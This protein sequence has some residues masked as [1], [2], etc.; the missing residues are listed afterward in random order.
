[1]QKISLAVLLM[2]ALTQSFAAGAPD[3]E[4]KQLEAMLKTHG[5]TGNIEAALPKRLGRPIDQ[6]KADLGR[7]IFFD[8]ALGLHKSNSCSGCH[9]PTTGLGDTQ[10]I[11]IGIQSNDIVGPDRK[12][13]RNQ[14][15][16]PTVVNT[17]FYPALMWNGRFSSASGNPFD[18]SKGFVFPDP[19]GTYSFVG[20]EPHIRHLLVAQAHIPF[21]ELPEMAGFTGAAATGVPLCQFTLPKSAPSPMQAKS[22]AVKSVSVQRQRLFNFAA[23]P[24]FCQFDDGQG[25]A[26]PRKFPDSDY[27]NAP[28][29]HKVMQEI[30]LIE[31]Y[32]SL[33]GAVYPSVKSGNTI[34][35]WM[36]GQA[37]A[38]FQMLQT[39]ANAPIDRFARG[40]RTAL[41]A[42]AKRGAILFFGKAQCVSCHAV[43]GQSNEM[44]SDFKMHNAGVPQI[45]PIFGKLT[46]N[47]PFRDES[48]TLSS[49]GKLD[50]GQWEFTGNDDDKFKFRTSPLRNV[51]LQPTYF[52]NGAF[53]RLSDA[54]RFHVDTLRLAKSYDPATAGVAQ[55]LKKGIGAD[56]P[57]D[58][59][60]TT[61]SPA[62]RKPLALSPDEF[63]SLLAFLTQGLTDN[64]AKPDNLMKL[65][66]PSLPSG[67]KV[68]TFQKP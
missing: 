50:L 30:N 14:R 35:F 21:T 49:I 26:L 38:E 27:L 43:K 29:R 36:I 39:Y 52:H 44:F 24:D 17:A 7:M 12:G 13:P 67:A 9:S 33:F 15:R 4:S 5:F 68:Q 46:G 37:L 32:R 51:A 59:V 47:V 3:S 10:S 28:I 56:D 54:L 53:T 6:A 40:E 42:P 19:E 48:G 55:D 41:S 65:I 20:N 64:R 62:L 57:T 11:A 1:M 45:A 34:E 18:N 31:N 61:L 23:A 25:T 63:D 16:T 58:R 22:G 66:P 8:K 2:L 60:L